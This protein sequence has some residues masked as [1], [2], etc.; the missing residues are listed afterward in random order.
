MW[1]CKNTQFFY[2]I[3]FITTDTDIT[4]SFIIF[5]LDFCYNLQFYFSASPSHQVTCQFP[6][7][8]PSKYI[9]SICLTHIIIVLSGF[10]TFK[11]KAPKMIL[12]VLCDFMSQFHSHFFILI[13]FI[14]FIVVLLQCPNSH[15]SQQPI[16]TLSSMHK[17]HLYLLFN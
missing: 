13:S 9:G 17:G 4:Q 15:P 1:E 3:F 14:F 5:S 7:S 10:L 2:Y 12:K 8:Y 16:P 6:G 11:S